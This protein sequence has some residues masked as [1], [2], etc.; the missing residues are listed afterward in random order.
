MESKHVALFY[1]KYSH[2][3]KYKIDEYK[4]VIRDKERTKMKCV[5]FGYA[6]LERE[7]DFWLQTEVSKPIFQ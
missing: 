2:S 4:I 5:V 7:E 6:W 1:F 3:Y